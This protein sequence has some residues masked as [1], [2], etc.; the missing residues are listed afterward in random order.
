MLDNQ[1]R[2]KGI[3]GSPQLYIV[4]AGIYGLLQTKKINLYSDRKCQ[5]VLIL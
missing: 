4:D 1:V 3:L 2:V 5:A